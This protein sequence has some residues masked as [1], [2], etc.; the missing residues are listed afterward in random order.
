MYATALL[1]LLFLGVGYHLLPGHGTGAAGFGR[2]VVQFGGGSPLA[3]S[4]SDVSL[5][6]HRSLSFFFP[7]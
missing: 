1:A 3:S 7:V 5:Q 4:P 2:T 6:N